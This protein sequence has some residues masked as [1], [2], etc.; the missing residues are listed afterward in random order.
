MTKNNFA[1]DNFIPI[2]KLGAANGCSDVSVYKRNPKMFQRFPG[3]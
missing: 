1:A 2:M 3:I